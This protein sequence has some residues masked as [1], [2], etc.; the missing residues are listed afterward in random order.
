MA[1]EVI[2]VLEGGLL[3]TVQDLGRYGYQRYGV[4]VSGALDQ[5]ALRVA[6]ILVGNQEGDAGLEITMSGP[7]LRFLAEAV[8]ANAGGDLDPRLDDRPLPMW[9]AVAVPEG[10]VLSFGGMRDGM[11]AYLA[12]AG[13]IDVPLVLGSRSTYTRSRLGGLEG[14]ALKPGDRLASPGDGPLTRAEG[15]ELSREQVPAYGHSHLLR[16]VLGPQ[17]DAFTQE[18]THTFCSSTYTVTPQSDRIGFRLQGPRIQHKKGADIVSDGIPFGAVQVAG[19]GMPI[20]LLADRG[21][22]GGYTKIATVASVD[23]SRLAQAAP[24]DTVTFRSVT[25]AEAQEALSQQEAMI[26]RLKDAPAIV[27]ARRRFRAMVE[28]RA[29]EAV[30]GLEEI[31]PGALPSGTPLVAPG[32]V[33]R[34][35]AG[36]EQYTFEVAVEVSSGQ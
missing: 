12:F 22:T 28:G 36:G 1:T 4:P 29:Y 2:D 20:V 24:G 3:T 13:G 19:D 27:F 35:T 23:I 6:N 15:R 33:V 26:R 5:F 32:R 34:A 18:G 17:D 30:G 9:R 8:F 10:S 11:R 7:R 31:T 14:R 16:V 25:V 21:A